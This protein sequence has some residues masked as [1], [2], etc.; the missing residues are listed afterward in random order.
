[1]KSASIAAVAACLLD[2][3]VVLLPTDTV[4]GLAALPAS[5]A[6]VETLYRIKNRPRSRPLPVM[7][8]DPQ[9]LAGLGVAVNRRAAGL[10]ASPFMPGP[11]TL[12]LGFG[13]GPRPAWLA[14]RVEM[15][16]RIPDD[17]WLRQLLRRCGPLYVTSANPHGLP[18]LETPGEI[19]ATLPE[20]PAMVVDDGP[21]QMVPSTLVNCCSEPPVVEREG[22]VPLASLAAF[23]Q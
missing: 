20:Q 4:Y 7:V 19:L 3:G 6:A 15:A 23:L 1:M 17:T 8:A 5:A 22:A 18:T 11:L 21:R 16:I 2:G 12:A 14:G 13:E 10:L 9:D